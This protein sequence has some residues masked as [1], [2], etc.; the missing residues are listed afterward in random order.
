MCIADC[1]YTHVSEESGTTTTNTKTITYTDNK[2]TQV[3]YSSGDTATYT[4]DT[5]GNITKVV[6]GGTTNYIYDTLGRLVR[7][8]NQPLDKT[9]TYAYDNSWTDQLT[10]YD[11]SSIT[12]DDYG[13]SAAYLY[14]AM[15]CTRGRLLYSYKPSGATYDVN[16]WYNTDGIRTNNTLAVSCCR[17]CHVVFRIL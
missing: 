10:S 11:G 16:M 2:P 5:A 1:Q 13:N 15:S 9:Y 12:Y 8:D 14:G 6:D 17:C 3:V 4:Y 7:E